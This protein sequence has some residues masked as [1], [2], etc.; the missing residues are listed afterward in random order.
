MARPPREL[1]DRL[2]AGLPDRARA[3]LEAVRDAAGRRGLELFLVGGGVRDL[4]LGSGHLDV[5]LVLEG[6]ALD[7]A[8]EAGRALGA[9]V[10]THPRFGTAAISGAGFRIDLARARRERYE[11]P[12]ALPA[13]EPGTLDDDLARRDFTIN[14]MALG[15]TG[16]VRGQ[17]VDP[18]GGRVDLKRKL[19]RVLHDASFADDPTR[20]LRALR[21]AGRLGFGIEPNTAELLE[22]DLTLVGAVTGARLRHEFE[23]IALEERGEAIVR[24][25]AAR[26]VLGA[27]QAALRPGE[28][29][30]CA[31]GR[32]PE[33]SPSLRDA[34][35]F[36]LLLAGARDAFEQAA[37]RLALTGRQARAVAGFHALLRSEESLARKDLRPSEAT[38]LLA[39]YAVASVE[40]FALVSTKPAAVERARRYLD[41]WRF[42][43][44]RLNGRDVE[45][46]GVT[47]GPEIGRAL[48]ALRA[49]RLDGRTL[50]RADEEALVLDL[51]RS[52]RAGAA[53]VR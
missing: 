26:G 25:A 18:H 2:L 52:A 7:L 31:L 13:V 43:R 12:G 3:A 16:G 14:A 47:Q 34:V 10:V 1:V 45:A 28:R 29:A 15:L 46:L 38:A 33:L 39:P 21:Y 48:D 53:H 37:A 44:P 35:F 27:V 20:V 8:G 51:Q 50:S 19:V 11:R 23:R 40:A 4:L 36:C 32:L 6:D 41:L 5:D 9:R 22:R 30:L 24:G 17:L 42:V 49:A